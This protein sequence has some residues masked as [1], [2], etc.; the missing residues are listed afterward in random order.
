MLW[1]AGMSKVSPR[2]S[3]RSRKGLRGRSAF[4][5]GA[6]KCS[7]WMV[8]GG[9]ATYH[10][11]DRLHEPGRPAKIEVRPGFIGLEQAR[12]VQPAA[13]GRRRRSER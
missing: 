9:Q 11:F 8:W 3:R 5:A 1:S 12:N 2:A 13:T 6:E 10:L 7:K 4:P